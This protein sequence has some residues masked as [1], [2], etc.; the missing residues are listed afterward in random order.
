MAQFEVAAGQKAALFGN[1]EY[2]P[3][4]SVI[5]WDETLNRMVFDATR[6]EEHW[7]DGRIVFV[8]AYEATPEPSFVPDFTV[9]R[10]LSGEFEP[11]LRALADEFR[12]FGKPMFFETAREPNGALV[13]FGLGG[14][15][16]HGDKNF[17]WALANGGLADFDPS[18]FPNASLYADLGDPTI[19]DGIERLIAAQRYYYHFFVEEQGLAFLTFEGMGWAAN[20]FEM[21]NDQI[22]DDFGVAPGSPGWRLMETTFSYQYFYPGDAY[23]DWVSITW[24]MTDFGGPHQSNAWHIERLRRTLDKISTIAHG[25]P[26]LLVEMGLFDGSETEPSIKVE[27]VTDGLTELL[28]HPEINGF[29]M[30][31]KSPDSDTFDFLIRPGTPEGDA[32]RSIIDANKDEFYSSV[33]FTDGSKMAN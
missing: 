1:I 15:G 9:D 13:P 8:S 19:S 32:F 21:M 25:K 4:L 18:S 23:V 30:W 31:S 5:R 20:P 12:S 24:Y 29:A 2:D 33:Y 6:A 26:V 16:P 10:L 3:D 27:K 28:K 11:Q 14:F 22:A 17:E 7:R